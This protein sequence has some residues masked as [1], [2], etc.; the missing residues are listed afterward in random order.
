MSRE[1]G[2]LR[3]GL[4]LILFFSLFSVPVYAEIISGEIVDQEGNPIPGAD[5]LVSD[6]G[7]ITGSTI[8]DELGLFEIDASQNAT[9]LIVYADDSSSLGIDYVP[10]QVSINTENRIILIDGASITVKGSVQFVDTENLPINTYY[11]ILD[12][13]GKVMDLTGI[14]LTYNT[15]GNIFR[16]IPSYNEEQLI[17]PASTNIKLR[18][19]ATIVRGS[20]LFEI[21]LVTETILSMSQGNVYQIEISEYVFPL[22][23][24]KSLSKL[25]ELS[26]R[27]E[28]MADYGFYLERQKSAL[29][30]SMTLFDEAGSLRSLGK[31]SE[32]FVTLKRSYILSRHTIQEVSSMFQ[33]ASLS[34]NIL[35]GFLALSS[36]VLGYLLV[37]KLRFQLVADIVI[38][39]VQGIIFYFIYPGS[40]I[41]SLD[42]FVRSSVVYFISFGLLGYYLPKLIGSKGWDERVHTRNLLVPIF[43]IAKRSLLRRRL[44]FLLTMTSLT[45]LVMSFVT[46]TSFSESYGLIITENSKPS[47][48]NGVFIR[49]STWKEDAPSFINLNQVEEQWLRDFP[50]ITA[51]SIKVE[52][53]P[54]RRSFIYL[55]TAPIT[56]VLGISKDEL[57]IIDSIILSGSIPD[58][59]GIMISKALAESIQLTIGDAVHLPYFNLEVQ[60]I[61]DDTAFRRLKDL[62]GTEYIPN[63]WVNIGPPG[64]PGQWHL[65]PSETHEVI[66]L[67]VNN[68]LKVPLTGIQ[69]LGLELNNVSKGVKVAERLSLER[70]YQSTALL[71]DEQIS[72]RLGNYF[73]GRGFSLAIP[74]A[75]VVLNVVITMMNAMFERR[76]EIEVLSSIGLNPAQVSAIFLAEAMITGFIAGGFGYLLGLG[77]YKILTILNIGL[78]VH[79]KV[80]AVWS[81]ASIGLAI[82]AVLSGS[83]IALRNSVVI[84]PSLMRRWKVGSQA[85]LSAPFEINIPL[86]LL[87]EEVIPYR[88]YIFHRLRAHR[89]DPVK[90]TSSIKYSEI[91]NG[92]LITFIYK[93]TS[94]ITGNFY[95]SNNL[96]ISLNEDEEYRVKLMSRGESDWAHDI[97]TLIRLFSMDFSTKKGK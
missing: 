72:I 80:S 52:N 68:A 18:I 3:Y 77:I 93:S 86:K 28:E 30:E 23:N 69:R 70:G 47:D 55:E 26:S 21:T 90:M 78:Q 36:L 56:G 29:S 4:F 76:G 96:Y 19:N 65:K 7:T 79:Q 46:L 6:H 8:S 2:N 83:F 73:E 37:E 51:I 95:T 63:K 11:S 10:T 94:N 15:Q 91:E 81:V 43:A 58:D 38:F 17:V 35:I 22:N 50:E 49:A 64:E 88:D 48:W 75:I 33:D 62:D 12:E 42:A 97:G 54:Q 40:R 67:S 41:I 1:L 89:T 16:K 13:N 92:W 61:L 85:N 57:S 31:H 39:L 66:I 5:I 53:I 45:L 34:T 87:S 60:G 84:T 25:N 44:R 14:P 27:L 71:P 32:A 20:K 24:E 82:S 9:S 74:W 59:N